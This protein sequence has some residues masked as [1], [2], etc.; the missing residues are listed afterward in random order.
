MRTTA[1]GREGAG[2][3]GDGGT[4]SNI[5]VV[6][7]EGDTIDEPVA[8]L[9]RGLVKSYGFS[10]DHGNCVTCR[11]SNGGVCPLKAE[12]RCSSDIFDCERLARGDFCG[13]AGI[14]NF[15]E[16]DGVEGRDG[17]GDDAGVGE[18][19][20]NCLELDSVLSMVVCL[21]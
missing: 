1:G 13:E 6:S 19:G 2:V 9:A 14:L 17:A 11:E 7:S 16:C 8:V 4:S 10:I 15:E 5:Q 21:G 3:G 20:T 12:R 18:M